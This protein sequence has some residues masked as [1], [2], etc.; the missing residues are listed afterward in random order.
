ME[1]KG[2]VFHFDGQCLVDLDVFVNEPKTFEPETGKYGHVQQPYRRLTGFDPKFFPEGKR[3][4][5]QL[6]LRIQRPPGEGYMV[7]LYPRLKKDDPPAKFT[8]LS[9]NAVKVETPLSTDYVFLSPWP[10]SFAN[11]KVKFEGMAGA[12]RF[13]NGG[14]VAVVGNEGHTEVHVGGK[15]I[16]GQGAFVVTLDGGKA[17]SKTY[18]EGAEVEV[19]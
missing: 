16:R 15:T 3:R 8:R 5:D 17:E 7:V 9:P 12:V 11:E 19:E 6:L 4:E 1:R 10:F 2:D 13:Y 18:T 14:K